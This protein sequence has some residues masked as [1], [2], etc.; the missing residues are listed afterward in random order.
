MKFE[1]Y[2]LLFIYD[3]V[4]FRNCRLFLAQHFNRN[5][6]HLCIHHFMGSI[7][8]VLEKFEERDIRLFIL[9]IT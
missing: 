9:C 4:V 2:T 5:L 7:P 8:G 3:N 6:K 1:N